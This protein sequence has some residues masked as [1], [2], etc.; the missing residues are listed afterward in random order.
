MGRKKLPR[1]IRVC[2]AEGCINTFE[3]KITAGQRFCSLQC[4]ASYVNSPEIIAKR[5][6]TASGQTRSPEACANIS[7]A[8]HEAYLRLTPEQLADRCA[9]ATIGQI[10][11]FKKPEEREK[12][13]VSHK[14]LCSGA[15]SVHWKGEDHYRGSYHPNFTEAF[16]VK[17]RDR[18][19]HICQICKLREEQV[20]RVLSVHHIHYDK[21]NDCSKDEDFISLCV[22]CH[23]STN[24][25]CEYWTEK[26]KGASAIYSIGVYFGIGSDRTLVPGLRFDGKDM[27]PEKK[28]KK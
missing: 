21:M 25:N 3:V 5:A 1:V 9:N 18:D 28:E 26:L 10:N 13:R 19:G 4:S 24:H 11:R 17:I 23:I 12:Q 27:L 8:V 16:K 7:K 2:F 6:K 22:S 14:G 15:D 20:G